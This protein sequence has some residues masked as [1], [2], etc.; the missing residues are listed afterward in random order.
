MWDRRHRR[1][2]REL[3][4]LAALDLEA[5]VLDLGPGVPCQMTAASHVRP[6][7]GVGEPLEPRPQRR[8]GDYVLIEAKLATRAGD[9]VR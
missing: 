3:K 9:S 7:R 4:S 8:L 5:S 2:W 1:A 6:E